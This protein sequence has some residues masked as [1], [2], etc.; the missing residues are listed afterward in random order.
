AS[1]GA[2]I[3]VDARGTSGA[4]ILFETSDDNGWLIELAARSIRRPVTSSLFYT[5]YR[6]LPNDTDLTVFRPAGLAGWNFAHIRK[7]IHYHRPLDNLETLSPSTV[8][9]HGDNAL[10]MARALGQASL[11]SPP[12]ERVVFFDLFAL[13]IARWPE[14]ATLPVAVGAACLV[15]IGLILGFRGGGLTLRSLVLGLVASIVALGIAFRVC[16]GVAAIAA[17]AG[18]LPTQ[19]IAHPFPL[20]LCLWAAALGG[21]LLAYRLLGFSAGSGGVWAGAWMLWAAA[22]VFLAAV[23]P[24]ASYLFLVP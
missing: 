21:T 4:S 1:V 7:V 23:A 19:W 3:N 24:G 20:R 10:A 11:S 6:R 17:A 9:H 15:G 8:Q 5:I 22:S 12:D 2:V 13:G 18:A 16:R 14:S